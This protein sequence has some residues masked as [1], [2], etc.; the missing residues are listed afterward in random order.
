MRIFEIMAA[1]GMVLTDRLAPQ[2]GLSH[3]FREGEHLAA[4]GSIGE[5]L[6]KIEHYLDHP[7]EAARIAAAG[8]AHYG[9]HFAPGRG[10]ECL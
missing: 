5:L 9:E 10:A 2:F 7:E 3:L 6:E 8:E 1:G 4:Y